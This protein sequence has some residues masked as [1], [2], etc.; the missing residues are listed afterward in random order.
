MHDCVVLQAARTLLTIITADAPHPHEPL[1]DFYAA[2]TA[3]GLYGESRP[4]YDYGLYEDDKERRTQLVKQSI[5]L[6]EDLLVKYAPI[7]VLGGICDGGLI[8]AYVA[9]THPEL[10]LLLNVCG[11]PW[12]L[13]P[14]PIRHNGLRVTIPSLHLLGGLIVVGRRLIE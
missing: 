7:H 9:S 10:H 13:L 14:E 11:M 1:P 3:T 6:V 2:L 8:A 5:T 12:E 4:Y